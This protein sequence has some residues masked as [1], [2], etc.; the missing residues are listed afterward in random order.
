M[1]FAV[2]D[3]VRITESG[4]FNGRTYT[5]AGVIIEH[6]QIWPGRWVLVRLTHTDPVRVLMHPGD[7][8]LYEYSELEH[9]D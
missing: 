8:H 3:R 5:H 1:E 4:S 9:I 6:S 7:R 2:G